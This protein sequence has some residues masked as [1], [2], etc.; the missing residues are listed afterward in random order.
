MKEIAEKFKKGWWHWGIYALKIALGSSV[1]IFIANII[2]LQFATQA[3]VI[4]VF[5][6]LATAKDTIKI[7]FVRLVSYIVTAVAAAIAFYFFKSEW[8]AYGVYIF[9][10]LFFAEMM[11]WQAALAANVVAGTHFFS[12]DVFAF[13]VVI[14]EFYIICLGQLVALILNTMR[15]TDEQEVQLRTA[16]RDIQGRMQGLLLDTIDYIESDGQNK[17][18][19]PELKETMELL[20]HYILKSAEYEGNKFEGDA[21]YFLRYFEMRRNQLM[22][23]RNLH[24]EL[25]R[26]KEMP[27]QAQVIATYIAYMSEYVTELNVPTKQL[28]YLDELFKQ[29][30]NEP[31]PVTRSEF[32]NR[33][34]LY[35]VLMELEDFL[36]IKK[37]Y[38]E[39]EEKYQKNL[40]ELEEWKKNYVDLHD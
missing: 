34:C 16:I 22:V 9:I 13:D 23:I 21:G 14:N 2:G 28:E 11:G 10:T 33:A 40:R 35:H 5:S 15:N 36:I 30:A 26:M 25:R 1:A 24:G 17:Q 7:S 8:L 27:V 18:I 39:E 6:M 20:D 12:I 29:M 32:E 4:C 38:L 19:W 31:L 3:G 37:R